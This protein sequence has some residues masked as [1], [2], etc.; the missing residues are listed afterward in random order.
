MIFGTGFAVHSMGRFHCIHLDAEYV[1][2]Q[3]YLRDLL[4][5]IAPTFRI[6]DQNVQTIKIGMVKYMVGTMFKRLFMVNCQL[7]MLKV[8]FCN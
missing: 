7:L 3:C 6:G 4:D 2:S 8:L 5:Y 1:Y